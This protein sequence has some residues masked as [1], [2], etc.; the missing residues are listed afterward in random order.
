[1][2]VNIHRWLM[3]TMMRMARTVRDPE[4]ELPPMDKPTTYADVL[5]PQLGRGFSYSELVQL[6][7]YNKML[8]PRQMWS[9]MLP[10]LAL[11]NELREVMVRQHGAKGLR[12]A[13]AY[14]PTGGAKASQ[15]KVNRALDIDLLPA[16]YSL[17]TA[18][19]LTAVRLWQQWQEREKVGIGFYCP[20][21]SKGGIRVHLDT[22]FR[23]RSWQIWKGKSVSPSPLL[24][25]LVGDE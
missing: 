21:D 16:D 4:L 22:G 11:A 12:V 1:M 9:R 14:R 6:D 15:H 3:D 17:S 24:G 25:K 19:Y 5:A 20:L 23:T 13:A 2:I 7:K 18:Y 8:P 10:T